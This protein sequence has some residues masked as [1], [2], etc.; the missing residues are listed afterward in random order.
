MLGAIRQRLHFVIV[1]EAGVLEFR[2]QQLAVAGNFERAGASG[3]DL[4]GRT[5][6]FEQ[7]PRTERTRLVV[8][9]LAVFDLEVH[10]A[11][12]MVAL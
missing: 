3:R 1:G 6:L 5:K 11:H 4:D 12:P 7:V 9:N 8:S 2:E 10:L